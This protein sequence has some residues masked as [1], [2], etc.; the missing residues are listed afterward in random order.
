M[1][2]RYS[3]SQVQAAASELKVIVYASLLNGP[4]LASTVLLVD[5]PPTVPSLSAPVTQSG[6]TANTRLWTH[7]LVGSTC[8]A[9]LGELLFAVAS[10]AEIG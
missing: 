3:V 8:A 4:D 1:Q 7:G 5:V 2:Q 10:S 9:A 6:E